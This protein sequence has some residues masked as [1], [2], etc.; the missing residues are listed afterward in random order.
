[1]RADRL[2]SML[3]I[4]QNR[5]MTSAQ[6]LANE[7]EV[8][9]RTI[10]RDV[11]ALSTAGVPVYAEKGPGGGIALVERYR[12]DLTGLNKDEVRA[13]FMMSVPPALTELGLD[14]QLRAAML[15]LSSALPSNMRQD[16]QSI[17]QRIYIDPHPWEDRPAQNETADLKIL[18]EAVWDTR[19]L[20]VRHRSWL[21]PDL[22]PM[23]SQVQPYGLVAKDGQW[24][25]VGRREDHIAVIRVDRIEGVQL[26][27]DSFDRPDD[28]NLVSFWRSYCTDRIERRSEYPVV[29]RTDPGKINWIQWVLGDKVNLLVLD[30]QN[31]NP[32]KSVLVEL[33]FEYF[34]PALHGLLSLGGAVE[35]VEPIAM[36]YA[37]KDYA[38]QIVGKYA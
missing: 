22:E 2:L 13:L 35:V 14:Q 38:E 34:T 8:S 7:L 29:A 25:L 4:L 23:L 24:Y 5:G 31:L 3:L 32:N 6:E 28:F 37:I 20:A 33:I 11:N 21:R 27:S 36:R 26:L 12:S 19:V 1:M 30:G 9:K 10:Y 17:R 15:K 18:Q 16:E